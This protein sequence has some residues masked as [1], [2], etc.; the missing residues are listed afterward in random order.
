MLDWASRAPRRDRLANRLPESD[1]QAIVFEPITAR[2]NL[3]QRRLG[4]LGRFRSHQAPSIRNP[5]DV[6]VDADAGFA[7]RFGY[8]QVWSFAADALERQQLVDLVR[9]SAAELAEQIATKIGRA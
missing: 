8:H 7:E 6:R 1:Q 4:M 9:H 2:Q 5:M 3:S